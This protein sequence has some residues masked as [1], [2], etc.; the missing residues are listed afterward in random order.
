MRAIRKTSGKWLPFDEEI[1]FKGVV[2]GFGIVLNNTTDGMSIGRRLACSNPE[3]P[4]QLNWTEQKEIA[5]FHRTI[6]APLAPEVL[7][8][9]LF[10]LLVF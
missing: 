5:S 8:A 10:F 9:A 7:F 4:V 2:M 3:L 6:L 1:V